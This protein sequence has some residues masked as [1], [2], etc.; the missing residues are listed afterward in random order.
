MK[1]I[2]VMGSKGALGLEVVK[3]F[4][5]HKVEILEIHRKNFDLN[6][7][8][9]EIYKYIKNLN[10]ELL[11]NCIALTGLDRCFINRK[12]AY[13]LNARLPELLSSVC[14]DLG[15][16]MIQFSTDNIFSCNKRGYL[17]NENDTPAPETWYG[18]TKYFGEYT[19][20][21]S[22]ANIIRLPML[23]GPTNDY[24]II[25]KIFA[26]LMQGEEVFIS[27][28][29]YTTPVYTPDIVGWL[30][31]TIVIEKKNL[32]EV[33]HLSSNKLVSLYELVQNIASLTDKNFNL[34]RVSSNHFQTLEEKPKHG[35]LSSLIEIPFNYSNSIQKYAFYL[36]AKYERSR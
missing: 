30:I 14:K 11:I 7:N 27:N 28:D 16:R 36:G 21:K 22:G 8:I 3:Q 12:E 6:S 23:F 29:V 10:I 15:I 9:N 1:K 19:A 32:P 25:G 2:L 13:I 33:V 17:Y 35:G 20:Y 5:I 18:M 24:Q 34:K 31:K 26:K 4:Y